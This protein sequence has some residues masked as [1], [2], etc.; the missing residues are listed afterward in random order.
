MSIR[1]RGTKRQS[2]SR[3]AQLEEKLEDLVRM[4]RDQN[5]AKQLPSKG[6]P[7][8]DSDAGIPSPSN[9][10]P[11]DPSA[12][13]G[14]DKPSPSDV[15]GYGAT[16]QARPAALSSDASPPALCNPQPDSPPAALV[17]PSGNTVGSRAEAEAGLRYFRSHY[18]ETFPCV[19]LPPDMTA[20][21]LRQEKPFL[22]FNILAMTCRP[23]TRQIEMGETIKKIVAQKLVVEHEYSID[24]LLGLLVF[25]AWYMHPINTSLI[26]VSGTVR[27]QALLSV[28]H[29]SG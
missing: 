4:L 20:E 19:Y 22:W 23:A 3:T 10:S 26:S 21:Q 1:K 2:S 15:P 9:T 29:V 17:N 18:L 12:S 28:G 6:Y 5:A 16:S 13:G 7:H 24:M 25:I 8:Q 11:R 27:L 14:S